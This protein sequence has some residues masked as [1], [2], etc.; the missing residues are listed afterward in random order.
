MSNAGHLFIGHL[1][2]R[3][4]WER[5]I[6]RCYIPV[7]YRWNSTKSSLN[8]NHLLF[9]RQTDVTPLQH[10]YMNA[11]EA[12]EFDKKKWPKS[13]ELKKI[14]F[15]GYLAANGYCIAF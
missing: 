7:I 10:R 4:E 11:N 6:K 3:M 15:R 2:L 8:S 1:W 13:F 5:S 9:S 12:I 14:G